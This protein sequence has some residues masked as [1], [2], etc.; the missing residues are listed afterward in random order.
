[1]LRVVSG[2]V[3]GYLVIVLLTLLLFSASYLLL[4]PERAFAEASLEVTG[5][6]VAVSL[7]ISVGVALLGGQV[8]A[9]VGKRVEAVAG[10]AM[11]LLLLGFLSA[12]M[13]LQQ[14]APEVVD[15]GTLGVFE[16]ARYA[17]Q[18]VWFAWLVPLIGAGFV[19][20]GG[21]RTA[22]ALSR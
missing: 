8:A 6:W 1:M 3:A 22:A 13:G 7:V 19:L 11:V 5:M 4:G 17:R 18:P 20:L 15:P 2:A 12:W 16:A 10:L 21:Y 14:A 9:R